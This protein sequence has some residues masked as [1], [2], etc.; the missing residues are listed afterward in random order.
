MRKKKEMKKRR[1]IAKSV[2]V[3]FLFAAAT[4]LGAQQSNGSLQQKYESLKISLLPDQAAP[5]YLN[6]VPTEGFQQIN[7]PTFLRLAGF[8]K[9][10]HLSASHQFLKWG[11]FWGGLGVSAVGLGVMSL[12]LIAPQH[13]QNYDFTYMIVGASVAFGA[14]IPSIISIGIPLDT[15]PYG[16]AQQIAQ[17]Y[18]DALIEKL[19]DQNKASSN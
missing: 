12:Q 2:C 4:T 16:R 14:L 11:L 3:V 8:E 10:A 13:S 6:W 15:M 5:T 1:T 17:D 9:E 19:N 18:N 7:E